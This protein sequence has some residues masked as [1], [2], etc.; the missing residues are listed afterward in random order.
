MPT[1]RQQ[2]FAFYPLLLV[3]VDDDDDDDNLHR[4]HLTYLRS[5]FPYCQKKKD[6]EQTYYLMR[7]TCIGIYT[8]IRRKTGTI[9][10]FSSHQNIC[11]KT[12][13]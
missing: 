7:I 11:T 12:T 4:K 1:V 5:H 6:K 2:V 13:Y 8:W 3:N 10:R 9:I